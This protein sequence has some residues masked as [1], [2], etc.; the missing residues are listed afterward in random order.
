MQSLPPWAGAGRV[1]LRDRVMFPSPPHVREQEVQGLQALKPPSSGHGVKEQLSCPC[2]QVLGGEKGPQCHGETA[3]PGGDCRVALS[4][5]TGFAWG[6][7]DRP[8]PASGW[9]WTGCEPAA[10]S[11][12]DISVPL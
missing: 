10:P 3:M 2:W 8:D 11:Q 9:A 7:L 4:S 5:D 1:Q 6:V 12:F